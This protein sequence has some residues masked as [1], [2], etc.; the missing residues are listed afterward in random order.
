MSD[1]LA[2]QHHQEAMRK[3]AKETFQSFK[4]RTHT[5]ESIQKQVNTYK[6]KYHNDEEFRN[7]CTRGAICQRQPIYEIDANGNIIAEFESLA[8]ALL[9]KGHT[10]LN[11]VGHLK[12]VADKFNKNGTRSRFVGSYWSLKNKM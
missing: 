4:G 10:N 1:P 9:S 11:D 12:R 8:A 3:R 6:L 2:R 7:R 5:K